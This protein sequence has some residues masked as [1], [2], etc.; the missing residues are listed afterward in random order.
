MKFV[1]DMVVHEGT[2]G[3]ARALLERAEGES[4]QGRVIG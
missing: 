2:L 4:R 3:P 1:D